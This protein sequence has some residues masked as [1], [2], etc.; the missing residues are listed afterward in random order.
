MRSIS[1][2]TIVR[3]STYY[4]RVLAPKRVHHITSKR[5]VVKSLKTD[6][7]LESRAKVASKYHLI[8]KLKCMSANTSQNELQALFDEVPIIN[9]LLIL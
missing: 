4:L 5:E 3:N 1:S 2:Y 9:R 8:R 6:S 7:L